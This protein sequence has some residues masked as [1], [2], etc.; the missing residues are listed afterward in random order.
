VRVHTGAAASSSAWALNAV[1]YTVGNDIVFG[2]SQYAPDTRA[3]QQLLAHELVHTVQ[4]GRN[5]VGLSQSLDVA[6]EHEADHVSHAVADLATV[7]KISHRTAQAVARQMV[8]KN[9]TSLSDAELERERERVQRWLT[10][11]RIVELDYEPT[12]EYFATI[13]QEAQ[14][15]SSAAQPAAA[16][17]VLRDPILPTIGGDDKEGLVRLM[18]IVQ[19]V[20]PSQVASGLYVLRLGGREIGL[21]LAQRDD[22]YAKAGK[23]IRDSL[24]L[25]T[26]KASYAKARYDAQSDIDRQHYLTSS[27]VRLFGSVKDPGPIL[28][29]E[30]SKAQS[31][32]SSALVSLEAGD[33]SRA[34]ALLADTE[35]AAITA[36]KLWQAYFEGIIG[37]AEMTVTVLEYTRDTSFV[38]LG[39]LAVIA[40]GGAAAGAAG[41]AGTTT[42]IAGA[43]VGTVT[44]ANVIATGAPIVANVAGA[45]VGAALGDPVDWTSVVVDSAAQVI[46]ARFGGKL[47]SGIFKALFGHPAVQKLGP[48]VVQRIITGVLTHEV[49]TGF[50]TTVQA[51]YRKL[52]G[53][54]ITWD[55]FID[56]L[57]ARLTDPRGI[58]VASIMAAVVAGADVTVGG[59]R[60]VDIVDSRGKKLGNFDAIRGGTLV[61][62]KGARGLGTIPP[63]QSRPAQTEAQWAEKHIYEAT[64]KRIANLPV[65]S[66][67]TP[68]TGRGGSQVIPTV[69]EVQ[70]I[71]K[72][73]FKID[74]DTPKLRTEVERQLGR[75]RGDHA[76]WTFSATYGGNN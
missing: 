44:A 28:L 4:Q 12:R 18:E 42:T 39:V 25:A 14:R 23:A 46:L 52:K 2:E 70:G 22:V 1:A 41:A 57:V 40:T 16:S 37:S 29:S 49:T 26:S 8:T 20:R 32:A 66:T 27:V 36:Q 61:E 60:E 6:A 45:G 75:L 68:E 74:A 63:G 47:S 24:R 35:T 33:L 15:R 54:P 56:E 62:E 67:T 73:V 64:S 10:E 69:Q 55:R 58:I 65:A 19:G 38:T 3:G 43:E 5:S 11:H 13:E 31:S 9:V 17:P 53:Q 34:A 71:R 48:L 7:S 72:Y 30:A 50:S 21:T 76:D 51:V 59:V